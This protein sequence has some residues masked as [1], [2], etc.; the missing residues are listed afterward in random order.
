MYNATQGT[1]R[2]SREDE[3]G[4]LLCRIIE[5]DINYDKRNRM[6]IRAV[7]LALYIGY[8]AGFRI[9]PKEQ[10]W[11]VAFIELPTGQ[12]SWHL[13]PHKHEWDGHTTEAKFQRIK[14]W[15]FNP[16]VK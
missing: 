14:D 3:L 7:S 5:N 1:E 6:V 15:F 10:D 2:P 4:L 16:T 12:V 13:P 9:D 11:P 8:D